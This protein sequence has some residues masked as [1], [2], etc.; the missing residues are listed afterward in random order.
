[1]CSFVCLA[2]LG[3]NWSPILFVAVAQTLDTVGNAF[4]SSLQCLL[5]VESLKSPRNP[6]ID[7]SA[8]NHP[9]LLV[10]VSDEMLIMTHNHQASAEILHGVND[11]IDTKCFPKDGSMKTRL[12]YRQASWNAIAKKIFLLTSPCPSGWSVDP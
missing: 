11:R 8:S 5:F 1:M 12:S 10:S 3:W 2:C 4:V 7:F 9:H 6:P